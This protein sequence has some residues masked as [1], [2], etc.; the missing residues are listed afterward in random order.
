MAYKNWTN[1]KYKACA[2]AND[3]KLIPTFN[4]INS[5]SFISSGLF[6]IF[7]VAFYIEQQTI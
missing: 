7:P 4:P 2:L 3:T 6:I 1:V 5:M